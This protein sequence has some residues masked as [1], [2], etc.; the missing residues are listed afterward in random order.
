V[1]VFSVLLL[2]LV[3]IG[4]LVAAAYWLRNE[5]QRSSAEAIRLSQGHF[6][7]QAS[8]TFDLAQ[9]RTQGRLDLAT[10]DIEQLV[11]PLR[12]QVATLAN[13]Q[14]ALGGQ[15]TNL[16]DRTSALTQVLGA[17]PAR[18]QWGEDNLRRLVHLAGLTE[19]VHVDVQP[20]FT[21]EGRVVRPD[22]VVHLAADEKVIVDAK[23]PM[24]A[25]QKSV[26]AAERDDA[27][28]WGKEHAS[29]L[30][31]H[32]RDLGKKP[33]SSAV[34]GA[35]DF[36]VLYLPYEGAIDLAHQHD[37][38]LFEF[39]A[40]NKVHLA[41]PHTLI[42]LLNTVALGWQQ[43]RLA[44]SAERIVALGTRLYERIGVVAGHLNSVGKGIEAAGAAYN[45]AVGSVESQLLT[46]AR[47]LRT[48]GVSSAKPDPE[49]VI[50]DVAARAFV[51]PETT[52]DQSHAA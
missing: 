41:T 51:K 6:L 25:F 19:G 20:S 18:G 5:F 24:D 17:R 22:L 52:T 30:K 35:L 2:V 8:A 14:A 9:E 33:Y 10:K 50:T 34:P 32:I 27:T 13:Q 4:V 40:A 1:T 45:K 49:I 44:E 29:A 37:S 16:G 38:S 15:V 48:I 21:V 11:N 31:G 7:E 23:A 42:A 36:V 12:E 46:T 26:S 39:A 3:L 28:R 47:E 43:R